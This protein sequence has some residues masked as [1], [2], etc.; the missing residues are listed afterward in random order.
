MSAQDLYEQLAAEVR[1]GLVLLRR[2]MHAKRP[3]LFSE[4]RRGSFRLG[5]RYSVSVAV[6]K[7]CPATVS[8][9][10]STDQG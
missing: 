3:L 9:P 10:G 1:P 5:N 7:A 6:A 8:K 4:V 2:G